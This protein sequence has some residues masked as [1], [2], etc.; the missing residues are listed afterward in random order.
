[1]NLCHTYHARPPRAGGPALRI[2]IRRTKIFF[3]MYMYTMV[4]AITG[5]AGIYH[6]HHPVTS[7]LYM[8]QD[9]ASATLVALRFG[10]ECR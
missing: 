4:Y 9:W 7:T 1:M 2:R 3:P 5:S 10:G 6:P 8:Q